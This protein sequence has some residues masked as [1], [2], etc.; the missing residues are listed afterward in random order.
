MT[1]Q[2]IEVVIKKVTDLI[3]YD[4]NPMIHKKSFNALV[5]SIEKDGFYGAILIDQEG[6]IICG[7]NRRNAA[8]H[9]GHE[10]IPCIVRTVESD[11]EY[12][13]IMSRDNKIAALSKE[14]PQ[15]M[16]DLMEIINPNKKPMI[17]RDMKEIDKLFGIERDADGNELSPADF[18]DSGTVDV[19]YEEPTMK[20]TFT[21]TKGNHEKVTEKLR[22]YKIEHN[23]KDESQALL[24]LL[25]NIKAA[26]KSVR[27]AGPVKVVSTEEE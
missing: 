5:E 6:R 3:P 14:D 21:L 2:T 27:K 12:L 20:K 11:E 15:A 25:R 7:H 24:H 17:G 4:G 18:G 23:L 10:T 9:L 26:P 22:S 16:R 1:E 8:I 13:D 19:E